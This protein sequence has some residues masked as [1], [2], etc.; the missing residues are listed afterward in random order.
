MHR[1]CSSQ[2]HPSSADLIIMNILIDLRC[3]TSSRWLCASFE[4]FG[5]DDC[6]T[7]PCYGVLVTA[8]ARS[9][10][11]G[12]AWRR[13]AFTS[14]VLMS[15]CP[16]RSALPPSV[17]IYIF[18]RQNPGWTFINHNAL[19][20][21]LHI[22]MCYSAN[23][24]FMSTCSLVSTCE[25]LLVLVSTCEYFLVLW[26]LVSTCT[27]HPHYNMVIPVY[28]LVGCCTYSVSCTFTSICKLHATFE[29]ILFFVTLSLRVMC[30]CKCKLLLLS[31]GAITM[32]IYA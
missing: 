29:T 13:I 19:L 5:C 27:L 28:I 18:S 20:T 3:V 7:E 31:N 12:R 11:R 10:S 4:R 15:A 2:F 14:S 21:L 26:V 6:R 32:Y 17:Y 30:K 9:T 24:L 1:K 8:C 22:C 23:T 16:T 25:Y